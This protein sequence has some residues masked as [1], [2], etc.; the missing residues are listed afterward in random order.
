[1]KA[2]VFLFDTLNRR[3]L[4]VY[5]NEWVQTPNISRFAQRSVVFDN[6]WVGSAPC[7]PARR[8]LFTGRLNFLERNWGPIEPFD[9]TLPQVLRQNGV[10]SHI[11]TDHYHYFRIGGENYCQQFDTWELIRGQ[12][13]DPW[14]SRVNQEAVPLHLGKF[15]PQ[16]WQNRTKFRREEN[17]PGPMTLQAAAQWLENN[18][19]ADNYLLWVEV[20]DP[21]EPFDFP[22]EYLKEYGDDYKGPLC[23][24]PEYKEVNIPSEALEH[25][26]KRY[27]ALLTMTDHWFGKVLDI[28][29][30]QGLWDDTLMA[31]T[32]DHGY[33]LGEHGF[34]AK[35]YMPAYNE[36]F[37]IP[38]LLH[39]PGDQSS[40]RRIQ[41][42]TQNIDLFPTLMD[43]FG[44]NSGA[45]PNPLHGGS[46]LPLLQGDAE[47]IRDC[48]IYGYFGKD[49]NITDGRYTYFR[50]AAKESNGPL[51]VYTAMPMTLNQYLDCDCLKDLSRIEMGAFL[52]WTPYPVYKIPGE[53][54]QMRDQTQS[55][56]KRSP[57]LEQNLLFDIENDYLQ[58]K[59]ILD[60]ELEKNMCKA[61]IAAM[62]RHDAPKEQ[63]KRL[64][65]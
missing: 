6:H 56:D 14:V 41:A 58:E 44:I 17:Y 24:W 53:I 46:W 12:E 63:L 16:Y 52:P 42:L 55:F 4:P 2:I 61:L 19:D 5:G 40:G 13:N 28:I 9:C 45:C 25:L 59:P 39:L 35:N 27:A 60:G 11:V 29:D 3:H 34:M 10:Y 54:I 31:L 33:M 23:A 65:L 38:L 43:Y 48:A 22:P 1:M 47:K 51:N 26:R 62:R 21:H 64:G 57:L 20:F 15:T 30:R 32:A 37:H 50:A 49:V 36:V 18:K 7:I 8:D